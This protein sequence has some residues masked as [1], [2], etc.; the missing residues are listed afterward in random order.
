MRLSKG[1]IPLLALQALQPL[2]HLPDDG[3]RDDEE[4]ER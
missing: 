2:A 4:E 1:S 3:D